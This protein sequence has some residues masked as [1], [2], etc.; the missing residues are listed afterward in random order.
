MDHLDEGIDTSCILSIKQNIRAIYFGSSVLKKKNEMNGK[1][2]DQ[3]NNFKT[4][5]TIVNHL[6]KNI[7]RGDYISANDPFRV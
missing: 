2:M 1:L 3:G 4:F 7:N 5:Q 6:V